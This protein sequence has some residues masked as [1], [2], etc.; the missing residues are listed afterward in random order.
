VFKFLILLP[1]TMFFVWW[2]YLNDRG[3]TLKQGLKGFI[4]IFAFNAIVIAFFMLMIV[5]TRNT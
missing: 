5:L 4:Y 2:W 1:V 3:Y